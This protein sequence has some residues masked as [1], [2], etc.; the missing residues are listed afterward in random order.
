M[1]AAVYRQYGP[2]EVVRV[3]EVPR[4]IPRANEILVKVRASTV[5]SADARVRSLRVP[6]GFGIFARPAFG[7]FGPRQPILGTELAGEVEA[8]GS[9]V[10][11]YAVGDAVFAFLGV[12]MGAHAEYRAVP[13]EG[14]VALLPEGFSFE[15]AAALSFGGTTALTHLRDGAKVAPGERVLVVGASGAV[16]SAAV[17]IAKHLGAVVTGVTSTANVDRVR[18][19]GAD[20][21]I[22]YTRGGYLDGSTTYDVIYDTVGVHDHAA[23]K[24][25]L[26]ERG[27]LILAA[28]SLPQIL[29]GVWASMTTKHKVIAGPAR[30][31]AEDVRFLRDAA[32]QGKIRPLIDETFPLDRIVEA[33]ARVD[34][35]RKRGSVVV[36]MA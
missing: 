31:N 12:S 1:K 17:Q 19:L 28:A 13:E 26:T 36:T 20:H 23:C 32:L 21:V 5:A 18:A 6:A 3:E 29:A 14:C 30:E 11:R 10:R 34:S 35:G 16:G 2:P 24:A 9:A 15:E 8:V 33:H 27:R 25:A 4:P 7:F 22:D